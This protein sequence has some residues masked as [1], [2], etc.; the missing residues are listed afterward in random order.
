VDVS[1]DSLSKPCRSLTLCAVPPQV[2]C[3]CIARLAPCNND[4]ASGG[5]RNGERRRNQVST[6]LTCPDDI[7]C[8]LFGASCDKPGCDV[9]GTNVIDQSSVEFDFKQGGSWDSCPFGQKVC[10]NPVDSDAFFTRLGLV[11]GGIKLGEIATV[12]TNE[13]CEDSKLGAV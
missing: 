6:G 8:Q 3:R 1:K 4:I 11:S 12:D 5:N 2:C 7:D 13:I 9:Q 10:C